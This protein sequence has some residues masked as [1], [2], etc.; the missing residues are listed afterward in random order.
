MS[1]RKCLWLELG[2]AEVQDFRHEMSVI[3]L[4][5]N[6]YHYNY[7]VGMLGYSA[8]TKD[9]VRPPAYRHYNLG[10]RQCEVSSFMSQSGDA[11]TAFFSGHQKQRGTGEINLTAP[12]QSSGG[13]AFFETHSK[14]FYHRCHDAT[15]CFPLNKAVF[16]QLMTSR[17]HELSLGRG[18]SN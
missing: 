15:P 17:W 7:W 6:H 8:N 12:C 5:S 16:R 11:R 9:R 4:D 18:D 10:G 1:D 3:Y 14:L 2:E 13:A